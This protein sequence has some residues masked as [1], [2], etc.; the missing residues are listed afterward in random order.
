MKVT[1]HIVTTVSS[2]LLAQ[3]PG[4]RQPW[5]RYIIRHNY[6]SGAHSLSSNPLGFLDDLELDMRTTT[7]IKDMLGPG[8]VGRG[9]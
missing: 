7:A 4:W 6:V 5:Q 3:L 9:L 1:W 8:L 2:V